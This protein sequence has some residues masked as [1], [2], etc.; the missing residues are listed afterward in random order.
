MSTRL[1]LITALALSVPLVL[2]A[3]AYARRLRR[4]AQIPP[5]YERVLILGASSGI[6][7]ALASEYAARGARVCLVGRRAEQ[8]EEAA[9]ECRVLSGKNKH[10]EYQA[11]GRRVLAVEA[12]ITSVDE[13]VR[14]R[15]TIETGQ[16]PALPPSGRGC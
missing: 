9:E 13:M 14:V 3:R 6:G 8:L 2:R 4:L 11:G 12:D 16:S 15:D 10:A 7:R 5:A 1:A